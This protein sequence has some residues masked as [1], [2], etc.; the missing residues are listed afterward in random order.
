MRC[1]ATLRPV[2]RR[3][4][5]PAT[6]ARA[7][8]LSR[9]CSAAEVV[10]R[11]HAEGH[12]TVTREA[13]RLWV[14]D[15]KASPPRPGVPSP[16]PTPRRSARRE[17]DEDLPPELRGLDLAA[18]DL[19]VLREL[20]KGIEDQLRGL[21]DEPRVWVAMVRLRMDIRSTMAKLRPPPTVDPD[22]DPLSLAARDAALAKI[23]KAL[24]AKAS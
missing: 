18:Q 10:A 3:A 6:K 9:V 24:A 19:H 13:V 16:A 23:R 11:L 15:A 2:T 20:D 17:G 12:P 5:D 7:L 14:N 22:A 4:T 21:E 1:Y 8:E